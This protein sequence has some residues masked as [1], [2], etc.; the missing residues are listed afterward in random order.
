M[1]DL[2]LDGWKEIRLVRRDGFIYGTRITGAGVVRSPG[3]HSGIGQFRDKS[4]LPSQGSTRADFGRVPSVGRSGFGPSLGERQGHRAVHPIP[5]PVP[6][7][8]L[9]SRQH[10]GAPMTS[11]YDSS[12]TNFRNNHFL[13]NVGLHTAHHKWP[14][15]HWSTLEFRTC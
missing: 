10:V 13:L 3:V 6:A 14:S 4:C 8:K 15:A 7:L 12:V 2:L 5:Q 9:K 11:V 1:G